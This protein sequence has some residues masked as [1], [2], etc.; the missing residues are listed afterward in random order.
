MVEYVF[1]T[2]REVIVVAPLVGFALNGTD[3]ILV[4]EY[5]VRMLTE[6]EITELVKHGYKLGFEQDYDFGDVETIWCVERIIKTA[7]RSTPPLEP[8]VRDFITLLRPLKPGI[9]HQGPILYYPRIWRTWWGMSLYGSEFEPGASYILERDDVQLLTSLLEQF[10]RVKDNF[11]NNIRF[12]LRW[13][14]KSYEE[15][16]GVD[17]VLDLAIALEVLFGVS[18]R[19][20]LYVPHLLVTNRDDRVKLSNIIRDLRKIRGAIAHCGYYEVSPAFINTI[21][22]IFRQ[23]LQKF[24]KLLVNQSYEEIIGEIRA[25]IME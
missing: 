12:A 21:E 7:K 23:S 19:L 14:N 2:H 3:E 5:K 10:E 9:V 15:S 20:D 13:F 11:L 8:D 16:E 25:S 17:R 4:G 6:W 24:L 22:D 18:D 1:T